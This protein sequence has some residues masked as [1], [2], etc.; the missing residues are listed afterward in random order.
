MRA[1]ND[2]LFCQPRD[3]QVVTIFL[4]LCVSKWERGMQNGVDSNIKTIGHKFEIPDLEYPSTNF[5]MFYAQL[6]K[7]K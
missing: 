7:Y 3:Q 6:E 5:S 1:L 2:L 4:L